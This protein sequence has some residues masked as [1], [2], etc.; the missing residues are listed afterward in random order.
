MCGI[1]AVSSSQDVAQTII[2][3]LK[4]LEYR[5]YD[6]SGLAIIEANKTI[7]CIKT[8][9]RVD[10]L[11][12][13]V[14]KHP[15]SGTLGIAHTR[16]ATH[17]L[18]N[19]SNAHP[20]ISKERIA[21][22]HNGVIENYITLKEKLTQL[23]YIFES[24]TDSEVIAHL[25][26][27]NLEKKYDIKKA[28]LKAVT[29][30]K[31][32]FSL[33]IIDAE[34]PDKVY[35]YCNGSP[36][37]IGKSTHAHYLASDQLALVEIT[38]QSL[39]LKNEEL[40]TL[41]P[42]DCVIQKGDEIIHRSFQKNIHNATDL[43]LGNYTTYT[44]KEINEQSVCLSECLE[45]RIDG[46][47]L[48]DNFI[49]ENSDALLKQVE[50]IQIVAC[51]TS[52]HAGLVAQFWFESINKIPTRVDI[53]SEYNY[54]ITPPTKNCLFISVSQSGETIDTLYALK[55][56]KKNGILTS[57][58]ITNRTKSA[59][60]DLSDYTMLTHAGPEIGVA[61]TKA[62]TTQ[63]TTLLLLSLKIYEIKN[64]K[65]PP[66]EYINDLKSLPSDVNSVLNTCKQYS[67]VMNQIFKNKGNALFL[68]RGIHCPIAMEGALKLKELSYIHAEAY[69]A[70]EL[71]HGPLA[72]VD[73][74]MPVVAVAPNDSL[75]DKL[76][77][78][79][80]EVQAR[81]GRLLVFADSQA[82]IS[83]LPPEITT[84]SLPI[85]SALTSPI[86]STIPLQWLAFQV[87]VAKGTDVDKPRNLAKSVTVE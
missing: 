41:S 20:H 68:G 69:P 17:G 84:I 12:K 32:A 46:I 60:V 83:D 26:H 45:G 1:F 51:G 31:G 3:G 23:G 47:K 5:G 9:G 27:H 22:V 64:N 10:H 87:A 43:E 49:G 18:P 55:Q 21:I 37:V 57:V 53:A 79:I 52:Y 67:D 86:L 61:S 29:H 6:S 54:K 4:R 36:I 38:D 40:V 44:E 8:N 11:E 72:M 35:G 59:L 85:R 24:H 30:L 75:L 39:S 65:P 78:N 19:T 7:N 81:R 74:E 82:N 71:K 13:L 73:S 50:S 25:I 80:N 76:K 15:P 16:W 33:A 63:L 56:G 77:T 28:I 70:G 62:F 42:G 14:K 48:T 58:A 66:V 2:D 34:Q